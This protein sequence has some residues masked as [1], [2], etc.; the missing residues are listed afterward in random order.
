[1]ES[2]ELLSFF[3]NPEMLGSLVTKL[4]PPIDYVGQNLASKLMYLIFGI[5]YTMALIAG[6]AFN[7]LTY[8]MYLGITTI[9]VS[10]IVVVPS[11]KFY[12]KN[13][14]KFRAP[15]KIKKE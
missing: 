14:L 4:D 5:G 10:I 7:D 12:R 11:W 2:I 9:A 6:I 15:V 13:P 1:M 8:T 3:K